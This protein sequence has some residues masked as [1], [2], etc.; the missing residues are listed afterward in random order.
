[1]RIT[2]YTALSQ[3]FQQRV[4]VRELRIGVVGLGYAG[5]PLALAFAEAGFS[6]TGIDLN[7]ERVAAV[8]AGRSYLVD[9]PD[10]RYSDAQGRLQA[11]TDASVI[12]DLDA[13]TICVPTPLAKTRSPDLT[14]VIAAAESIS[15]YLTGGQVVMLQSTT[16]PG[17]T[18]ELVLPILQ[19]DGR[20][21]GR[22]FFLGYAPERVDPG[23]VHY[24]CATRPS[25][26][27]GS[28]PRA[29]CAPRRSTAR[30]STRSSR[31]PAP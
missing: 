18:E 30:S 13:L 21:V 16:Y 22:D 8:N 5:L 23:N 2:E 3:D 9:V 28:P 26:S 31:S 12:R 10:E 25:W 17:T 29:G 27:V 14:F 6:V 7:A 20:E 15:E 24:T 4:D 19:R 11:T 1:M